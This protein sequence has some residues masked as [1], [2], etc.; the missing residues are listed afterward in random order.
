MFT[1]DRANW[2]VDEPQEPFT[3][4]VQ[5][6][7][8]ASAV[9]ATVTPLPGGRFQVVLEQQRHGVAPGQ[10]AVCYD[11]DRVLGGGWIE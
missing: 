1:A 6:R 10:A 11:A 7:Y 5:I 8:N 4:Q 2:L 3:C 9:P